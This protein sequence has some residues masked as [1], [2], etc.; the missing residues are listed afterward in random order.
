MGYWLFRTDP[1]ERSWDDVVAESADGLEWSGLRDDEVFDHF[2]GMKKGDL[3]VIYHAG[4]DNLMLGIAKT[5]GPAHP[6]TTDD[7]GQWLSIDVYAFIRLINQVSL[8]QLEGDERLAD[9]PIVNGNLS[10]VQPVDEDH[11]R[12]ICELAGMPRMIEAG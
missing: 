4:E 7:S 8:A 10:A 9:L 6:D 12:A 11:W 2:A 3:A 1:D 5:L